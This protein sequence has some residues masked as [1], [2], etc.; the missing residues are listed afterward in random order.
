MYVEYMASFL[1]QKFNVSSLAAAGEEAAR[2]EYIRRGYRILA[3]NVTNAR[4]KRIGEIDFIALG[5]GSINFVEV[6]TR[7]RTADRFG[8]ARHAVSYFKQKKLAK[9]AK[10]FLLKYAEYRY[11]RPQIDVCLVEPHQLD[12]GRFSVTILLHAVSDEP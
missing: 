9:I 11:L 1:S 8:G 6:K 7:S 2:Q 4:G 10:L 12:K 5:A 3:S